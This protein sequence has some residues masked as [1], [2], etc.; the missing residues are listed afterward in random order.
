MPSIGF[1]KPLHRDRI[2]F[3]LLGE[4]PLMQWGGNICRAIAIPDEYRS[5]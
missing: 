1:Q 5:C 3:P 2:F 4:C